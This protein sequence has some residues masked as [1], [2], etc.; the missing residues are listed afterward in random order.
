MR[1]INA[2]VIGTGFI[3][4]AHIEAARRT[5]IAEVV[6][7][8]DINDEIAQSKALQLGVKNYY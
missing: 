7:L 2:A 1:M 4:P 5:F 8:A 6:S 3:G